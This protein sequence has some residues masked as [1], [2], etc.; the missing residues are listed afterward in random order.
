MK[1]LQS[2]VPLL[3]EAT[4]GQTVSGHYGAFPEID[5]AATFLETGTTTSV[6]ATTVGSSGMTI[7]F[8]PQVVTVVTCFDGGKAMAGW[9]K[10]TGMVTFGWVMKLWGSTGTNNCG[11]AAVITGY[12]A[13][14]T[15]PFG[16]TAAGCL[17]NAQWAFNN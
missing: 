12:V 14:V 5:W 4:S 3:F 16:G 2:I 13:M 11:A 10:Y 8:N 15:T 9:G 6:T 17:T 7:G 1:L